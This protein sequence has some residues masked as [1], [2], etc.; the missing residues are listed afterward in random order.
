ML[1]CILY[2]YYN[3]IRISCKFESLNFYK[4]AKISSKVRNS[5]FLV[6]PRI[7]KYRIQNALIFSTSIPNLLRI[8]NFRTSNFLRYRE[9]STSS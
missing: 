3:S 7:L 4:R 1:M 5:K 2:V 6:T 8:S 9:F